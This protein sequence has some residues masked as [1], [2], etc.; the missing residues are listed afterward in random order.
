MK[1]NKAEL[2][3]FRLTLPEGI[4]KEYFSWLITC[5]CVPT[6]LFIINKMKLEPGN[7]NVKEWAKVLGMDGPLSEETD[8]SFRINILTGVQDKD[9]MRD[10]INPDIPI[11][12][13]EHEFGRGKKKETSTLVIDGNKR[14]RKAFLTGREQIKG[15]FIPKKLAKLCIL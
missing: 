11:I 12:V 9:A 4:Q 13:V 8:G 3:A 7:V 15:Y 2:E 6:A 5:Y 10:M 1:I 14:L